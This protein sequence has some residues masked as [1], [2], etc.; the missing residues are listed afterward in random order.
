[1]N[2]NFSIHKNAGMGLVRSFVKQNS[3]AQYIKEEFI[4]P[5]EFLNIDKC[6]D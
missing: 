6:E 2:F 1:M 4:D 3:A 5:D